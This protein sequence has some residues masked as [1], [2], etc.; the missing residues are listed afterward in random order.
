VAPDTGP[1][2][3][4]ICSLQCK[5]VRAGDDYVVNGQK[6]WT[7]LAMWSQWMI[8]LVHTDFEAPK[9]LASPACSSR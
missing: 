6:I 2:A 3:A 5:A 9:H 4:A 1:G 8:L 7:S